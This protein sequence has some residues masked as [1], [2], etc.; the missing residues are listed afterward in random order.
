MAK[1]ILIIED[2]A[3]LRCML[4]LA[5]RYMNYEPLEAEDGY[6]GIQTSL[7]E[8]PDLVLLDLGLP[9]MSGIDTARKIKENPKTG[10]IPIVALTGWEP[11]QFETR[12]RQVGM[13]A[14]LQKPVS[15]A[16]IVARIE[17]LTRPN[18]S[19]LSYSI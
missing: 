8:H 16:T 6:A 9:G 7:K 19:Q 1:K 13:A 3:Q 15:L 4:A 18:T 5:L 12:T 11:R 14:Y 17:S 10:E 2:Q